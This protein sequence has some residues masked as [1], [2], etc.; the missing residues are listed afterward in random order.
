MIDDGR[1]FEHMV[2][3]FG[4]AFVDNAC[5]LG[6]LEDLGSN[7]LAVSRDDVD[8]AALLLDAE[9]D[10]ARSQSE[11][12]VVAAAAEGREFLKS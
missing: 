10:R 4:G 1:S 9:L 3:A 7:A 6:L 5:C 11:Q 12:G 8:D 2:K